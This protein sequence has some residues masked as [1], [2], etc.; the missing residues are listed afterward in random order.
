MG[1]DVREYRKCTI[2]SFKHD[3]TPHRVWLENWEAAQPGAD[4]GQAGGRAWIL[5]NERTPVVEPNG[6][7]RVSQAPAVSFFFPGRWYNVAAL[8]ESGGIRYY[9]NLASPPERYDGVLA[10]ID[11]DVDVMLTPEGEVVELDR[12]EYRLYKAIYRYGDEIEAK[13]EAGLRELTAA[14]GRRAFPFDDAMIYEHYEK[15][16]RYR[17]A[18]GSGNRDD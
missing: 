2:K 8:L 10:Y 18:E 4:P 11:Y 13:I 17:L 16:K 9:C 6:K 3:G 15:W 5:L 1:S 12:E 14:I 7:I